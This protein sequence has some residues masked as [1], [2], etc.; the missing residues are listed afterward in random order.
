MTSNTDRIKSHTVPQERL[1]R[2][3]KQLHAVADASWKYTKEQV[4]DNELQKIVWAILAIWPCANSVQ[5]CIAV[6]IKD[7]SRQ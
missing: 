7:H 4:Y 5:K 2:K 1:D 6:A 3:K